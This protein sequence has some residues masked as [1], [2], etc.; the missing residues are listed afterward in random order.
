MSRVG[1]K[2]VLNPAQKN[3]RIDSHPGVRLIRLYKANYPYLV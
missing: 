3:G 2:L 1:Y